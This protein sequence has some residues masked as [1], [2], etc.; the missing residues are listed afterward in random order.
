MGGHFIQ[1]DVL[2]DDI[3]RQATF[4]TDTLPKVGEHATKLGVQ[5]P[6]AVASGLGQ[7]I[8]AVHIAEIALVGKHDGPR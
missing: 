7:G 1:T 3:R 4:R 5:S 8:S 2:E 6:S